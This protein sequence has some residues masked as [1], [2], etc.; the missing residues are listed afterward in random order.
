LTAF[1]FYSICN[2]C[3]LCWIDFS[4]IVTEFQESID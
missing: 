2:G 4:N 3:R 1:C